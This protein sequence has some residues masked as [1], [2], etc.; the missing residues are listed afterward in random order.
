MIVIS[1][2]GMR[3]F[4]SVD[5]GIDARIFGEWSLRRGECWRGDW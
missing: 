1:K 5:K 4:G 3:C 2:G